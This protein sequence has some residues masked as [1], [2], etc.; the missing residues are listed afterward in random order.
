MESANS[1]DRDNIDARISDRVSTES[2]LLLILLRSASKDEGFASI[3]T[4]V[5]NRAHIRMI[6]GR[7]GLRLAF[8]SPQGPRISGEIFR[9]KFQSH[10]AA[11]ANVCRLID[12]AHPAR[13]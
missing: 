13:A 7:R 1:G 2:A 5:I 3:F 8:E 9:E 10:G 4:N 11:Q 6:Q 12:D